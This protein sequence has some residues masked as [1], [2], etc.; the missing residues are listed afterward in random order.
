MVVF[1]LGS[2]V[3]KPEFVYFQSGFLAL[4]LLLVITGVVFPFRSLL[5]PMCVFGFVL[6]A[7]LAVLYFRPFADPGDQLLQSFQLIV[8]LISYLAVLVQS[9]SDVDGEYESTFYVLL[10]LNLL[11]CATL[12]AGVV[13]SPIR[14][15]CGVVKRSESGAVDEARCSCNQLCQRLFRSRSDKLSLLEQRLLEQ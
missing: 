11:C 13:Y 1:G 5:I 7:L 10:G 3:Y 8:V 12:V 14:F 6:I 4:K 15:L 2:Q 9:S